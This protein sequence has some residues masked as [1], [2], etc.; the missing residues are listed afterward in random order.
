MRWPL[1]SLTGPG[2][3]PPLLRKLGDF[4]DELSALL[5][6]LRGAPGG[7]PDLPGTTK[8][9]SPD[10]PSAPNRIGDHSDG[11]ADTTPGDTKTCTT[12]PVDVA[13]SWVQNAWYTLRPQ[14]RNRVSC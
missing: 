4:I 7:G 2:T 13:P 8:V 1:T 9:T 3:R 6:R 14:R 12:D 10:A 5:R 11:V